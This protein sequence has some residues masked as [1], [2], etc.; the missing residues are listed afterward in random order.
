[1]PCE[2]ATYQGCSEF[3]AGVSVMTLKMSIQLNVASEVKVR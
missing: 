3:E 1:M 2:G